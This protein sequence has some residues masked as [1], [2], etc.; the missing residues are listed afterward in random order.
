[1]LAL[2]RLRVAAHRWRIASIHV[3]GDYLVLGYR[4]AGLA[5]RLADTSGGRLRIVDTQSAYLPFDDGDRSPERVLAA[6]ESL[7]Q[8]A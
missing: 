3:E 6:A 2:A 5:R 7:L 4:S 8:P 1:M